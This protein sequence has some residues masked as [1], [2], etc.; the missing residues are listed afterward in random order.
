MTIL[1]MRLKGDK[2]YIK[3]SSDY[4]FTIPKNGTYELDIYEGMEIE[5]D[6]IPYLR[7]RAYE[8]AARKCAIGILK[9]GFISEGML[10]DKMRLKGH[11]NRFINFAVHYCKEYEL[12]DDKRFV[13]LAITSLRLK[14]KSNR[15][16]IDFLKKAKISSKLIERSKNQLS[17]EK[18]IKLLKDYIR[19]YYKLYEHKE[20]QE[21]YMIKALMRKGF[22]YDRIK[23]LVK[24]YMRNQKRKK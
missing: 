1:K 11:K 8:A 6:D 18:D 16:I 21:E 24:I 23:S 20:K 12:I 13:R 19:K 9:R 5:L 22:Q 15:H 14:G 2:I 17:D 10:R 3:T 4:V 7:L